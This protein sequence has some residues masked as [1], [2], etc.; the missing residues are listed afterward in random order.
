MYII[1]IRRTVRKDKVVEFLKSYKAQ[2]PDH[3][4]FI[5][6]RL[7]RVMADTDLPEPLRS[8]NITSGE[9]GITFVNVARWKS[10]E[11]FNTHFKPATTHEK[12]IEC[13]DRVRVV[14]EVI[15][16]SEPN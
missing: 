13:S 4:D 6:E 10:W 3:P 7:T 1:L 9:E 8:F 5:D 15:D 11:S 12:E 14:L 2:R 16:S